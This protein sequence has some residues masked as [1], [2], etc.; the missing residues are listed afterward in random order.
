MT[1]MKTRTDNDN[2]TKDLYYTFISHLLEIRKYYF[3]KNKKNMLSNTIFKDFILECKGY[4]VSPEKERALLIENR[5]KRNLRIM[6][7]YD[8]AD[9]VREADVHYIF[10]NS[11]G[12][13]IKNPKNLKLSEDQLNEEEIDDVTEVKDSSELKDLEE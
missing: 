11:S 3:D 1:L 10:A 9:G 5:K 12:N 8:P 2:D 7:A 6:F 13:P 4:A